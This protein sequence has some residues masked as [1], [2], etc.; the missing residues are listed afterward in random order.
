MVG[1]SNGEVEIMRRREFIIGLGFATAWPIATANA[2]PDVRALRGQILLMQAEAIADKLAQFIKEIQNEVGWTT[3]VPS[4][5]GYSIDQRR[6]DALRLL[7]QTPA[8]TE[9]SLLDVE[10]KEFYKASRL[11]MD[12]IGSGTDYSREAKF[13]ETVAKKIYYGAV[14]LRRESEPYMSFGLAGT[15]SDAGVSVIELNLGLLSDIVQQTKVGDRGVAYVV[16][17]QGRI[18][19][20]P[21]SVL[22]KSLRDLSSLAHVQEA[23]TSRSPGSA[24]IARDMNDQKVVAAYARVAGPGWLVFVELPIGEWT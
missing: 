23:R 3:Q 13:T 20:H 21:D 8:V 2:Q 5:G 7:R 17:T 16:D 18:I 24:R 12:V 9:L 11:A 4:T 1:P 6:F 10:G 15:R 19:A 14:Y 22:R